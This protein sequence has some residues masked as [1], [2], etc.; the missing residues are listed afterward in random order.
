VTVFPSLDVTVFPSLDVTVFPSLDVTVFPSLDVTVSPSHDVTVFPSL[1]VTVFPS[2]DVTV[3]PSL[4]VTVF[5]IPRDDYVTVNFDAG[6][7]FKSQWKIIK[8]LLCGYFHKDRLSDI[9]EWSSLTVQ[10]HISYT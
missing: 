7:I 3:F 9:S 6:K 1:D 2:H 5:N 8:F 4:D 10:T